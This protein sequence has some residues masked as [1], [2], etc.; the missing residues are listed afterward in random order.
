VRKGIFIIT[1]TTGILLV[2]LSQPSYSAIV[3][4]Y[5]RLNNAGEPFEVFLEAGSYQIVPIGITEGGLYNAWN[6]WNVTTCDKIGGCERTYYT[7]V[8]GWFN[9]YEVKSPYLDS[10]IING[11]II[12]PIE[13]APLLPPANELTLPPIAAFLNFFVSSD[14]DYDK[15]FHAEDGLCYSTDSDALANAQSVVFTLSQADSVKF[16]IWDTNLI[17]NSGGISL[18][19]QSVPIPGAALLLGSGLIGLL[20]LRRKFKR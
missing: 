6:P 1:V 5:S 18:S 3:N 14:T 4:I 9:G 2:G 10:V 12:D 13:A 16:Y 7:T 20:S 19:V 17:D 11:A 8:K 15:Y